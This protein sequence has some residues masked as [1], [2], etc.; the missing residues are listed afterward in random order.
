MRRTSLERSKNSAGRGCRS[1]QPPPTSHTPPSF[2][3]PARRGAACGAAGLGGGGQEAKPDKT[4]A[5]A[6]ERVRAKVVPSPLK[7]MRGS[8]G[9][10]PPFSRWGPSSPGGSRAAPR[11]RRRPS[12]AR[13]ERRLAEAPRRHG[14]RHA[15]EFKYNTAAG[16]TAMV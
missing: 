11:P 14:S 4:P 7:A 13:E 5:P 16:G 6:G 12:A 1:P 8:R 2:L 3:L 15:P 10:H 9:L